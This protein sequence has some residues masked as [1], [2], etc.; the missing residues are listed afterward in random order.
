MSMKKFLKLASALFVAGALTFSMAACNQ[1]TASQVDKTGAWET[2]SYVSDTEV[3]EG[4]KTMA[5]KVEADEQTVA[6]TVHSDA[7]TVGEALLENNL[8]DGEESEYGLYVKAVN[9]IVA[10]YDTDQTYWAF[11]KDGEYMQT[12]VDQTPLSDGDSYELV[13][14]KG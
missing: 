13:K 5:V 14:T 4:E 2:A 10:D 12:G 9:G 7:E 11:L 3:G 1:N 6:F 8:I